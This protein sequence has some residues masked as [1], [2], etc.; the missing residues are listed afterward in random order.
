MP[1]ACPFRAH[2]SLI[3]LVCLCRTGRR[4]LHSMRTLLH[5][6][7]CS[8]LVASS[9]AAIHSTCLYC[10]LSARQHLQDHERRQSV[11]QLP[12]CQLAIGRGIHDSQPLPMRACS[13]RM[14]LSDLSPTLLFRSFRRNK[15]T[16]DRTETALAQPVQPVI[17]SRPSAQRLAVRQLKP[18]PSRFECSCTSPLSAAG[19]LGLILSARS[20][21]CFH[22]CQRNARATRRQREP[23]LS[24]STRAKPIPVRP[25]VR[26][27][28]MSLLC[29]GVRC[30]QCLCLVCVCNNR[31]LWP[32]WFLSAT[33][34]CGKTAAAAAPFASS[35]PRVP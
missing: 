25:S 19:F 10:V 13:L 28:F 18:P 3:A 12:C 35:I 16:R 33:L 20:L 6:S 2:A 30:E 32:R 21:S 34:L 5:H 11:H 26:P 14:P 9:R 23:L 17:T 27:P 24:P 1:L 31:L 8:C 29:P 15:G 22:D 4:Y 7:C